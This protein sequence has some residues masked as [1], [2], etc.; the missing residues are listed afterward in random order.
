MKKICLVLT[1]Y[2]L[3][4]KNMYFSPFFV[5]ICSFSPK[6]TLLGHIFVPENVYTLLLVLKV[7]IVIRYR[8]K[9]IEIQGNSENCT[10]AFKFGC[11]V[12]FY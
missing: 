11:R 2:S 3:K 7:F 5:P 10:G 1:V 6:K 4:G 12:I 8:M 9:D